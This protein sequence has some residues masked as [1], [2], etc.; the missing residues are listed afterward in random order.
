MF[1]FSYG[2]QIVEII[3]VLFSN[4]PK[5]SGEL[6]LINPLLLQ[7]RRS[8]VEK[9]DQLYIKCIAYHLAVVLRRR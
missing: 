3:E 8:Y 1:F 9:N 7:S 6:L 5:M 2:R 4:G